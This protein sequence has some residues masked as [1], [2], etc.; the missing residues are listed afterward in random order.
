MEYNYIVKEGSKIL[1]KKKKIHNALSVIEC[2]DCGGYAASS[3]D[4]DYLPDFTFCKECYPSQK[5]FRS[6][7]LK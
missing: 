2:P 7:Y 4:F 6:Q 3:S 5:T 1:R